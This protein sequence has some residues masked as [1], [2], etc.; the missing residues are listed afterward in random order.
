MGNQASSPKSGAKLQVIGAGLPRTGTASFGE[1][2]RILLK[3]P[4]YHGGTQVTMGTEIE[5]LSCIKLLSHF[6]PQ[7]ASEKKLIFD[8][9]KQRYVGYVAVTDMPAA[10]LVEELVK[11]YPDAIIICTTR[12]PDSWVKNMESVQN[13]ATMG[14]L[15]FILF[16]IPGMRH[17]VNYINLLRKQWV[18]LYGEQEPVTSKSYYNHIAYLKRVVPPERLVFYDIKDGW[19]PLCKAL[20]KEIPKHI[21]FPRINDSEA[22]DRLAKK[23]V[24]KGLTRW[25]M[26]LATLGIPFISYALWKKQS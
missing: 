18:Y 5:I 2:L 4:V 10:G 19:E 16:P 24:M 11:I 15:R 6:P 20:G 22:I 26:I 25:L 12:S 9:F 21:E 8:I 3:G 17:F 13:A 14:F 1:A 23:K 7:N